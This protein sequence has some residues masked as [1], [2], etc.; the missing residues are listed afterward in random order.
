MAPDTFNKTEHLATRSNQ[1]SH[2]LR[3]LDISCL[4][5][6]L[7]ILQI[8]TPFENAWV[9]MKK[10]GVNM[11][12]RSLEDLKN[13]IKHVWISQVTPEYCQELSFNANTNPSCA[14]QQR[15][16][17]EVLKK[18]C[19]CHKLCAFALILNYLVTTVQCVLCS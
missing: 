4:P 15:T 3:H 18:D 14:R 13:N 9:I 1:L 11:H 17:H 7:A 12:P 5:R 2:G 16:A 10:A 8:L 6:G 19:S